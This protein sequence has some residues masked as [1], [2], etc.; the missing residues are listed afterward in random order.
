[1][2][3]HWNARLVAIGNRVLFACLALSSLYATT[4]PASVCRVTPAGSSG[5]SGT[6]A[7][8]LDL[9]SALGN[10]ACSE[11]WVK[12]GTYK[13]T[14]STDRNASF[15]L[16]RAVAVFGGF[17]G[18]ETVRTQRNPASHVSILSGDIGAGS[19]ASDNSYHVVY[20]VGDENSN[21]GNDTILD[22]FTITG[23]NADGASVPVFDGG[24]LLCE[25]QHAGGQCSPTLRQL[26]FTD[27][28]ASVNGGAMEIY[29]WVDAA[30]SPV[31]SDVQ[32]INNTAGSSGGGLDRSSQCDAMFT[33]ERATFDGNSAGDGGG[34]SLGSSAGVTLRDVTFAGNSAS[35]EGGAMNN[36]SLDSI[37]LDRVSFDGNSAGSMGGAMFTLSSVSGHTSLLDI[38]NSSF[39]NNT[40]LASGGNGQGGAMHNE[41]FG[42]NLSL[43]MDT[44]TL[45]NNQADFAGAIKNTDSYV[46]GALNVTMGN[47][48]FSNNSATT[49]GR[50]MTTSANYVPVSV[51]LR[52]VTIDSGAA[53]YY[54]LV[55]VSSGAGAVSTVLSNA[56]LWDSTPSLPITN[57]GASTTTIDHSIVVR[58]H[59]S[60][61]SWT[62][63]LGTDGGGNIDA[64]PMLAALAANGGATS[65]MI[66][67]AGSPAIDAGF[68]ATCAAMPVNNRDQRGGARP[69]GLQCDIG[70][71][72]VG[73]VSETIFADGFD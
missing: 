37:V 51:V 34:M 17:A 73:A 22:G 6:W 28:K 62:S 68:A 10:T 15:T 31:M 42:G 54:S 55:N 16:D 8:P 56:I 12:A 45:S 50:D 64:D 48:T 13:P 61:G 59:G 9:Q 23:G 39:N 18:T 47:V 41:A 24:G 60:G 27:N 35:G 69:H 67:A 33:L 38:S 49:S 46:G 58:S 53:G 57:S 21:I 5:G 70:A 44:V 19:D 30:A 40:A 4:A 71:I 3:C 26:R 14:N 72:E 20:M 65:T 11:I 2:P 1:M 43:V 29:C 66:P 32:F 63:S 7:S 52:N 36:F 25:G